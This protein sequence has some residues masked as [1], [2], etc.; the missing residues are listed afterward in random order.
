[1]T[2]SSRKAIDVVEASADATPIGLAE[3]NSVLRITATGDRVGA[4]VEL[5]RH[6]T[7]GNPG[8]LTTRTKGK[9]IGR[10]GGCL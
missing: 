10:P 3:D 8:D 6:G 2:P 9:W 4:V 7:N 1:L 5:D